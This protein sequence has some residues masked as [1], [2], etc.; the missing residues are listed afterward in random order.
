MA[1]LSDA[2][3]KTQT[4]ATTLPSWYTTAQQNVVNQAQQAQA[5][6][7]GQTVGGQQALSAFQA[8]QPYQQAAGM[9]GSIASG[10]ANPWT[11][12]T[13][14]EGEQT[15]SPNVATPLGGLFKAQTDYLTSMMPEVS[16]VPTAGAI[17]TGQFGSSANQAAVARARAQAIN[18][19]FQQQE[20]AALQSQQTGAS[21]AGALGTLGGSQLQNALNLATAEQ[22]SPY[23]SAINR[24]N[25]LAKMNQPGVTQTTSEKLGALSQLSALGTMGAGGFNSLFGGQPMI[26][27]DGRVMID[28]S[29]GKPMTTPGLLGSF[30]QQILSGI[31]SAFNAPPSGGTT[32]NFASEIAN[33]AAPG[34]A[35]Y[36][37]QYFS[38]G[39]SIDPSGN[40]YYDNN[41]VYSPDWSNYDTGSS[42]LDT[43]GGD[44][45]W[46]D[47]TDWSSFAG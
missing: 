3:T 39:T 42:G 32:D 22:S 24:A 27:P 1:G 2:L 41:L 5:P 7:L 12:T 10:A 14:P 36:G 47:N 21:A 6:Q 23:Q 31:K 38:N 33:T 28:P 17:S 43:T 29:T 26:G 18:Q 16:A 34:E 13:S 45:S 20:Q 4:I 30:G 35:G 46:I 11:V 15:V 44:T 19:L 40:Y 25:I 8:G 37:W 9:L